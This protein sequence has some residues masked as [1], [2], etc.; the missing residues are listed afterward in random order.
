M[1]GDF[2]PSFSG[3]VNQLY[4][5]NKALG[6]LGE[7]KLASLSENREP[8]RVLDDYW[9]DEVP[10]CLGQGLWR[11]ARRT[12]QQDAD[13]TFAP[14]FGFNYAFPYPS[15]WIRTVLVSTSPDLDPPL[16]QMRDEGGYIYANATPIYLSLLHL[17][18]C[19]IWWQRC[20][21]AIEL[22]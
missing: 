4:L 14:E 22:R 13:S 15:D 12:V 3:G 18:R 9:S 16:L 8:R 2:G 17:G 5:Y 7:R 11:F 10:F 6:Y 21:V 19:R 1:P 20:G